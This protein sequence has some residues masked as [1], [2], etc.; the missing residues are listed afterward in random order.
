MRKSAHVGHQRIVAET[1][2]PFRQTDVRIAAVNRFHDQVFHVPRCQK[3]PFFNI[4]DFTGLSGSD[5]QIPLPAQKGGNL[6]HIDMFGGN[7]ALFSFMNVGQNRATVQFFDFVKGF[8]AFFNA[9]AARRSQRGAVGLVIGSFENIV[10]AELFGHF[11]HGA[12]NV[13]GMLPA[14]DLAGTGNDC[15]RQFVADFKVSDFDRFLVFHQ[16]FLLSWG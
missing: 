14:F 15:Q 10:N 11:H 16:F 6:Q 5:Y 8:H 12:G 13:D 4:D 7:C 1:G 2:T 9:D 3:L